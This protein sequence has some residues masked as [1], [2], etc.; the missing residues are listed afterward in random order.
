MNK[1]ELKKT[2]T[3]QSDEQLAEACRAHDHAAFQELMHRYMRHIFHFARQ[4]A[5]TSEDADDI[6]Q[7][8][9]YKVWK[10]IK[11][12]TKNRSFK[13]WLYTIARNTAL[14]FLKKKKAIVFSD[15]D[16]LE[17]DLHFTDTLEDPAP[18]ASEVFENAAFIK[19]LQAA[20]GTIHPDHR[21]ILLLHY[22]ENMTFD[23]IAK[24][25]GRPMNT[26]KSWHRRALM[27]LRAEVE[28][29]EKKRK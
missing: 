15:I 20:L 4:Y 22:R 14:D 7:D 27:R 8:T 13:P 16:D 18:L 26:V 19:K 17:N 29:K 10:Y 12:Y 3:H 25:V 6:A 2:Y 5:K 24:I 21:A 23:E 28:K 1:T 11:K 9:F